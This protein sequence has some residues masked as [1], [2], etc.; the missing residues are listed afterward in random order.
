MNSKNISDV[1]SSPMF[2]G[3]RKSHKFNTTFIA[4]MLIAA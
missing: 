1:M 3:R 4:Y 2:G